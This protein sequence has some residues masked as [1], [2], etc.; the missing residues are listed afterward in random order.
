MYIPTYVGMSSCWVCVIV[1]CVCSE[2]GADV[3][4]RE[5][6]QAAVPEER[7]TVQLNIVCFCM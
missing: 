2:P 3:G 4:Q 6:Q 5:N 7:G 1:M